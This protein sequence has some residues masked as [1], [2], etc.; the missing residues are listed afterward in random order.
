MNDYKGYISR[1]HTIWCGGCSHWHTDAHEPTR[2]A[3]ARVMRKRGWKN[4]KANGWLCPSCKDKDK[5]EQK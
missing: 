3:M 2:A 1:E 5:D 4:T